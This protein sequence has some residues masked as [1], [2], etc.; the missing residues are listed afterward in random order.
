MPG[1]QLAGSGNKAGKLAVRRATSG[2]RGW[3]WVWRVSHHQV[4]HDH[5]GESVA[6]EAAGGDLAQLQL[7]HVALKHQHQRAQRGEGRHL[8]SGGRGRQIEP[9]GV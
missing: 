9:Q 6:A 3:V 2:L 1:V 8:S 4:R 5:V 7:A